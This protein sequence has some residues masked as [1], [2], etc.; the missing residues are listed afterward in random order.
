VFNVNELP[1]LAFVHDR[2]ILA[3]WLKNREVAE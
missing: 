3:D 2:G 1:E